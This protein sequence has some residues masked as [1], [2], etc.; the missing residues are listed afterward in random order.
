MRIVR[1]DIERPADVERF[2]FPFRLHHCY[3]IWVPPL[4]SEARSAPDRRRRRFYRHPTAGSCLAGQG[5]ETLGRIAAWTQARHGLPA[6]TFASREEM[7][8]RV[9]RV[10]EVHRQGLVD[11]HE[12]GERH[13]RP[14]AAGALRVPVRR[15][16]LC[17]ALCPGP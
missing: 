7:R 12:R 1:L 14:H 2:G 3:P 10:A 4:L 17:P 13:A 8:Q 6:K 9:P 11:G 5:R 16:R 15:D